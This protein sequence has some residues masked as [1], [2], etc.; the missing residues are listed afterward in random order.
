MP[1][2][3]EA[4]RARARLAAHRRWRPGDDL[5]QLTEECYRAL[6]ISN[7]DDAI[8]DLVAHAARLTDEQMARIRR[9]GNQPAAAGG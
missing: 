1:L 9:L 6:E 3:P 2:T 4:R 7:D 5:D 8:D